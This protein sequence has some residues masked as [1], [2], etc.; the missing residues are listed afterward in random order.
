[1]PSKRATTLTHDSID[2]FRNS[3]LEKNKSLATAKA[4]STDL[5]MMLEQM[6]LAAID[7]ADYSQVAS[8]WITKYHEIVSYKT[9]VRR[10][11]SARSFAKWA[12][13]SEEDEE[14]SEYTLPTPGRGIPHP[15][16][17][18]MVGVRRMILHAEQP[19]YACVVALCG[20]AGTRIGESLTVKPSDFDLTH[21]ML[22]IHG[23][24]KR[25]RRVPIS[26]ECWEVI[27]H[28]VM[29]AFCSGHDLPIVGLKDRFARAT[30]TRLGRKA[31]MSRAVSSHDLRATF[32][33]E[34]YNRTLDQRLVQEILGHASQDQTSLYIGRTLDHMHEGVAQL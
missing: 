17:E 20:M 9:T 1:M 31:G 12:R 32:A 24:G 34:L 19:N 13:W 16:P 28:S 15:L 25:E 10:M 5:R 27:S 4:Y 6:G 2:N 18:G 7:E 3:L 23:K 30:I 29:T 8:A 33:T 26:P 11:T 21:M 14:L 22:N